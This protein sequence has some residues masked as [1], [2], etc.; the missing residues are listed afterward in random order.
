MTGLAS[1]GVTAGHQS[2]RSDRSTAGVEDSL[3]GG[4][5]GRWLVKMGRVGKAREVAK[6]SSGNCA[7][8]VAKG[9]RKS[10]DPRKAPKRLQN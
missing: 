3:V 2:A 5:T 6:S 8:E 7:G 10:G 9:V 4:A 1:F